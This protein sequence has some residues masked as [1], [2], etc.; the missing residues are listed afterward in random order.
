VDT[1]K[2]RTRAADAYQFHREAGRG[3]HADD[4]D[5]GATEQIRVILDGDTRRVIGNGKVGNLTV[6]PFGGSPAVV[7]EWDDGLVTSESAN[8]DLPE[9]GGGSSVP[10]GNSEGDMLYWNNTTGAWVILEAPAPPATGKIN[11]LTHTGTV[12]QWET[13]DK[14]SINVCDG[15]SPT[16]WEI[17]KL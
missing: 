1:Y 13:K 15:G 5:T 7:L 16:T 14:K 17:I 8:I 10:D 2:Q 12:P 4:P 9:S 3:T 11:I 6:T